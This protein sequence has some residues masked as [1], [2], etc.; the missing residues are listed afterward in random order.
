[1]YRVTFIFVTTL[2]S[3]TLRNIVPFFSNDLRMKFYLFELFRLTR[4]ICLGTRSFNVR[5]SQVIF[6]IRLRRYLVMRNGNGLSI[7]TLNRNLNRVTSLHMMISRVRQKMSSYSMTITSNVI[8][9]PVLYYFRVSFKRNYSRT[10]YVITRRTRRLIV[11]VTAIA[12]CLFRVLSYF[13]TVT[14]FSLCIRRTFT[15]V[16]RVYMINVMIFGRSYYKDYLKDFGF[17][18]EKWY[19]YV[20]YRMIIRILSN[21]LGRSLENKVTSSFRDLLRMTTG[22]QLWS[23][24]DSRAKGFLVL[25]GISYTVMIFMMIFAGYAGRLIR[26]KYYL[27]VNT[28]VMMTTRL[29]G[30][31]VKVPRSTLSGPNFNLDSRISTRKVTL[32]M[33]TRGSSKNLYLNVYLCSLYCQ[34]RRRGR[35]MVIVRLSTVVIY[36][37]V[38]VSFPPVLVSENGSEIVLQFTSMNTGR[39]YSVLT[40]F[41]KEV[42]NDRRMNVNAYRR[43]KNA[44]NRN[45]NRLVRMNVRPDTMGLIRIILKVS[46][47]AVLHLSKLNTL[48]TFAS[49]MII[50]QS[51]SIVLERVN[52]LVLVVCSV[53][54]CLK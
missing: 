19:R 49:A 18:Y 25:F 17:H 35:T 30:I 40:S 46:G 28:T 4:R 43:T 53:K 11:I 38:L 45:V 41:G 10:Q 48:L 16:M 24:I 13:P 37:P 23:R 27:T 2:F 29:F 12:R 36:H 39:Q 50:V 32:Y 34:L 54:G 20:I 51:M 31:N 47:T 14:I 15:G 21:T 7:P 5:Y 1:M 22:L 9:W 6:V 26:P 3:N 8:M 44:L 52:I 42:M 33:I